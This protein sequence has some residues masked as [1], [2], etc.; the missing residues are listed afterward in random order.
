[1]KHP[2]AD[3][4][5]IKI[6]EIN[7]GTSKCSMEVQ[8]QFFNPNKVL[9]GGAIFSFADTGMGAALFPSLE[10]GYACASIEIKINYYRPVQSGTLIC[11]SKVLN[12]GKTIA[13][14]EASIYN[15]EKLV[16]TANGN[17][18]IFLPRFKEKK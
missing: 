16:A 14:V 13:N 12:K 11:L 6:E 15:G 1:M 4:L 3:L 2:F 9:H 17:F 8:E 7:T 5:G 18:S 10:K